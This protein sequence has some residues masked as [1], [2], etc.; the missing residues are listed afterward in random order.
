MLFRS[1]HAETL[2]KEIETEILLLKRQKLSGDVIPTEPTKLL[3]QATIRSFVTSFKEAS[4]NFLSMIAKSKGLSRDEMS[5]ARGEL[6]KVINQASETALRSSDAGL[7]AI[8]SE[9]S[10]TKTAGEKE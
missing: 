1:T 3:F 4:E 9:F 2:K 10:Q 5:T 7:N 6:I 8:V